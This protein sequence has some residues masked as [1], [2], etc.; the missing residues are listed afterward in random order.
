MF[1]VCRARKGPAAA[2]VPSFGTGSNIWLQLAESKVA[3]LNTKVVFV[4]PFCL[5]SEG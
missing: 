5:F 4:F 1:G 2:G 3:A